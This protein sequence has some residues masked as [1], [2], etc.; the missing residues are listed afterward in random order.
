LIARQVVRA[1][2]RLFV[3]KAQPIDAGRNCFKRPQ[4]KVGGTDPNNCRAD[5]CQ[6]PYDQILGN[7]RQ[8]FF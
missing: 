3:R 7:R 6:Q 1:D 8:Q 4:Q 2:P 5:D